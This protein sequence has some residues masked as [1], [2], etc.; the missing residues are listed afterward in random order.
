[1]AY[2]ARYAHLSPTEFGAMTPA[3]T[4]GLAKHVRALVEDEWGGYLEL[5]KIITLGA[6][7]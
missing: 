5:A 6:R 4:R 2:L 3:R 1:M 7:R